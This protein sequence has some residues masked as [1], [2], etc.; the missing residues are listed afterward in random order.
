MCHNIIDGRYHT[1]CS[2]FVHMS[3]QHQ[4]CLRPNCLFSR[5]HV[6]PTGCKSHSCIRLM[7]LP[8]KNPIRISPAACAICVAGNPAT[9]RP[10][11]S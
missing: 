8:V 11:E 9:V 2:H 10:M 4:D 3:T 1:P 5:R 7:A 6:H